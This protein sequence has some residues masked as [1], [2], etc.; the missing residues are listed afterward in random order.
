[1]KYSVN[2]LERILVFFKYVEFLSSDHP[3]SHIQWGI[4][5]YTLFQLLNVGILPMYT[6]SQTIYSSKSFWCS[7][8]YNSSWRRVVVRVSPTFWGLQQEDHPYE[9][10]TIEYINWSHPERAEAD[11]KERLFY[12]STTTLFSDRG[13]YVLLHG[14]NNL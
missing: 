6:Y 7:S 10:I 5:C 4:P 9:R 8:S 14:S 2:P 1:M 3:P 12:P 13:I 11:E